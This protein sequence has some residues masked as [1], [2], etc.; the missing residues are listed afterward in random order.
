M[1]K[2]IIAL[3]FP[4]Q[5]E[6]DLFLD[7]FDPKEV[8]FVKV[9][10]ELYYSCGPSIIRSIKA[11]GHALFL[12]LKLHDIPNTVESAMRSLATLNIDMVNVHAAGGSKMIQAAK[13]GLIEGTTKGHSV[14][15]LI[16]VTQLTSV[17]EET[18]HLEQLIPVSLL[19]SVVHYAV[20]AMNAGA[21]GVVCSPLEAQAVALATQAGFLRVTPGIRPS[22]TEHQDQ[23]RVTTPQVA[24]SIGSTHIVVGRPITQASDPV[25][26]YHQIEKEWNQ[27]L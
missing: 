4:S 14:P 10:M 9:G 17:S 6:V 25:S 5:R 18:M 20:L 1:D 12:D 24:R 13:K 8:L 2:P 16:A 26:A 27:A 22:S 11:R 15:K 21:D 7:R 23:V 19:E 3:D